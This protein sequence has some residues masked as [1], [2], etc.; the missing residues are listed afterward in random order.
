MTPEDESTIINEIQLLLSEKRTS[1]ST[2]RTG[3]AVLALPITVVG[4]LIATSNHY[5]ITRVLK[6]LIPLVALCFVLVVSGL[7]LIASAL[8]HLRHYDRRIRELKGKDREL[9]RLID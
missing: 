3:I 6:F 5:D 7:Y 2:I 4:L 9:G 1:L 8:V